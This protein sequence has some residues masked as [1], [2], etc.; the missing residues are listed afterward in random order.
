MVYGIASKSPSENTRSRQNTGNS[1]AIEFWT[2]KGFI[3]HSSS[4]NCIVLRRN[5]YGSVG[6][7][8]G[9]FVKEIVSEEKEI[10]FDEIPTELRVLCQVLPKEAKWD[11]SF[12]IGA[13]YR[14]NYP[15][16]F[17]TVVAYWCDEFARFCREWM[18]N[19]SG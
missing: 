7:I 10:D 6:K 12:K 8:V 4:Y 5:G 14:E 13:G 9:R 18:N 1:L 19:A 2:G 3:V 15:G 16:E 11:L 17:S